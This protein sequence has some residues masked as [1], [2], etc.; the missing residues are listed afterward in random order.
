[1][2]VLY[3]LKDAESETLE[4]FISTHKQEADV[5]IIKLQEVNAEELL[6]AIEESDKIISW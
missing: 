2:K 5:K 6:D 4:S 3:I 1:M